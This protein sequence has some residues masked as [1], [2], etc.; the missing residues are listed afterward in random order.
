MAEI[1][2]FPEPDFDPEE[3][4]IEDM[5]LPQLRFYLAGLEEVM[6][7]MDSREPRSRK[8]DA[9]DR[10]AEEH[11]DLEDLMDEIRD[12]MDELTD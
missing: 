7:E 8:T 2:P 5:T 3:M 9:Y 12:R 10:W 6:A 11:E 4:P 1:L